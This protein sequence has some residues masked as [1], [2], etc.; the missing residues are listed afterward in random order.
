MLILIHCPADQNEVI[1]V[2]LH[3]WQQ[4]LRAIGGAAFGFMLPVL[5]GLYSNGN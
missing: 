1:L 5:A 4:C 3:L 2:Q